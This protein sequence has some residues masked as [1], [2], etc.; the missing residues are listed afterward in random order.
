MK[1]ASACLIAVATLIGR[2]AGAADVDI[3]SSDIGGVVTG[4]H[5]GEAG[6]WVIAETRDL[7]TRFAKI[8]VTDEKGGFVIPDLPH[9]KYQVWVRGYG[10]IDSEKVDAVFWAGTTVRTNFL[11]T[12]GKGDHSKIFPRSPRLAFEQACRLV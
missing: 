5:G 10:L 4:D 6:V 8:V 3:S 1:S 12:L 9:A 2:S 11:C 7:A